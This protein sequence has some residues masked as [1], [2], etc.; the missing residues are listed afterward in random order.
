MNEEHSRVFISCGQRDGRERQ[1]AEEQF[2][3]M[4]KE[5][6]FEPYLATHDHTL[7]SIRENIF[8]RLSETKYFL[9]IDF[10]REKIE[11]PDVYRGSLFSHQELAIASFLDLNEDILAFQENGVKRDGVL[12]ETQVNATSFSERSELLEKIEQQVKDAWRSDWRRQL[13]LEQADDPTCEIVP[14]RS[15][16]QGSFF[17][18][19][20]RNRHVRAATRSCYGYLRSVRDAVS[21][22]TIPFESAELRWAGYC[23]PNA[24]IPP[25]ECYRKLDAVWFDSGD[26][27]QPRFNMFSDWPRCMP[28]LRGPGSWELEYEVTSENIL[29]SRITLSL[30]VCHNGEFACGQRGT[31]GDMDGKTMAGK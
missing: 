8:Q 22:R 15:S 13:V 11:D 6:G 26:P 21:N 28:N 9:F 18:I 17:H 10:R 31:S 30:D 5:Q 27:L 14:Q 20:V 4:L 7:R 16:T 24:I 23:L 2:W 12:D 25:K 29:G 3:A 1:V 19:K